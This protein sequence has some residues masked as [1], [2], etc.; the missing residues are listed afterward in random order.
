[1][2]PFSANIQ[3]TNVVGA[4]G[5]LEVVVHDGDENYFANSPNLTLTLGE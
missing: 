3:H 4:I 2:N 1:M 5:S